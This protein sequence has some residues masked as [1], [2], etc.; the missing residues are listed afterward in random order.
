MDNIH[1]LGI[2]HGL[3]VKL[4]YWKSRGRKFTH[5]LLCTP[6]EYQVVDLLLYQ[7]PFLLKCGKHENF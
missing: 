3:V 1:R 4:G 2:P 5:S 6:L 7:K